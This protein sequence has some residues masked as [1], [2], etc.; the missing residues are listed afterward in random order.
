MQV[1]VVGYGSLLCAEG[2]N[3]TL[4]RKIEQKDLEPVEVEGFVRTWSAGAPVVFEGEDTPSIAVFLDVTPVQGRN[5][6]AFALSLDE[7]EFE[8]IR[9]REKGYEMIDV[10]ERIPS[11][12]PG[13]RYFMAMVADG[14]KM[15]KP[16]AECFVPAAYEAFV[17][18]CLARL[19]ADFAR[20]FWRTTEPPS[21]RRKRAS[22]GLWMKRSTGIRADQDDCIGEREPSV[23]QSFS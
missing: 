1:K 2:W 12:E 14:K 3:R 20:T 18:K 23:W 11:A 9:K 17:K 22:T 15:R 4:E 21:F 19:S 16:C 10:T 7:R 13:S 8:M 5:I 6:N